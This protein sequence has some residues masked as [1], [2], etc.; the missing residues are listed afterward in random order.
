M[1]DSL[2]KNI[3]K[4]SDLLTIDSRLDGNVLKLRKFIPVNQLIVS[5]EV[6]INFNRYLQLKSYLRYEVIMMY[7]TL[8]DKTCMCMV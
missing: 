3:D 7:C 6:R 2:V 5:F 1:D 4:D 8:Y